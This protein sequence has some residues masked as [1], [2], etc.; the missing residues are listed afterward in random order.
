MRIMYYCTGDG[1]H[2]SYEDYINFGFIA[3]GQQ[4]TGKTKKLY[5]EELKLLKKGDYFFA[6]NKKKTEKK[7][8]FIAFGQILEEAKR[9]DDFRLDKYPNKGYGKLKH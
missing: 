4:G 9:I 5:S 6:F 1:K 2:R 8:G 7:Y 3:A